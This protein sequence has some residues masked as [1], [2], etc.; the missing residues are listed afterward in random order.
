MPKFSARRARLERW[1]LRGVL[2]AAFYVAIAMTVYRFAHPKQ[3]ETEILLNL[4]A[5]VTW[6]WGPP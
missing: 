2:A 1:A 3:T 4:W 6:Q 5:A